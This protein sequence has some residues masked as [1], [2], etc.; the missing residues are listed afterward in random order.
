[1]VKSV[2]F[3]PNVVEDRRLITGQNP[4]SAFELGKVLV[5][6]FD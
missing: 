5:R 6:H 1:M 4:Q 2:T 3:K